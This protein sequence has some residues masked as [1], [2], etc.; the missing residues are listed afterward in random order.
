[1]KRA[2]PDEKELL[3]RIADKEEG[4]QEAFRLLYDLHEGQLAAYVLRRIRHSEDAEDI[5]QEVWKAVYERA[6]G[7]VKGM[8]YTTFNSLLQGIALNKMTDYFRHKAVRRNTVAY[9]DAFRTPAEEGEEAQPASLEQLTLGDSDGLSTENVVSERELKNCIA[10]AVNELDS[11]DRLIYRMK[12]S[13]HNLHEIATTL[14]FALPTVRMRSSR[15]MQR[16]RKSL[17]SKGL[18]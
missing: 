11:T 15:L 4:W 6:D 2:K 1:M 17:Q 9:E 18:G 16:I 7:F 8:E 14:G 12:E 10:E 3:K 5:L 13:G